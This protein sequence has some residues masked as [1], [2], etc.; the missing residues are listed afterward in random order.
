MG[1]R[2]VDAEPI[3]QYALV[4]Y[5]P[6]E[7]GEFLDEMRK[8]LVPQCTARSHISLLPPR[9]LTVPVA[10][11]EQQIDGFSRNQQ[12]CVL[13]IGNVSV[14]PMTSV[15]YLEIE[16]GRE[17]VASMHGQLNQGAL[18]YNEPYPFHPH[19]TLAQNFDIATTMELYEQAK[20]MWGEFRGRREFLLD[21]VVFVQNS[22]T[23][24]WQDLRRY[25]LQGMPLEPAAVRRER[26]AGLFS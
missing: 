14:F 13:R 10:E 17:E 8:S 25:P 26:R 9:A 4:T 1:S 15:I 24:C 5:L 7:L 16:T 6:D 18:V 2:S 19:V 3:N 12:P 21:R 22:A 20:R 11:A 23:D